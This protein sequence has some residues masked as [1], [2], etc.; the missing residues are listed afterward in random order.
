MPIKDKLPK[1]IGINEY[2]A[3]IN[4]NGIA[5]PN[6]YWVEFHMP[7][8]VQDLTFV[9]TG[10]AAELSNPNILQNDIASVDNGL[11]E[12]GSISVMCTASQMPGRSLASN[13]H[14]HQN[15]PINIPY[16]VN[17]ESVTFG[18]ILSENLR[19]RRYF[20]LWQET[21][22]NVNDGSM[23]FYNEY[24]SNIY[25]HHLDKWNNIM[26]SVEL[27]EAWPSALSNIDH[28]YATENDLLNMSVTFNYK[29]WRNLDTGLI[30]QR[31]SKENRFEYEKNF[32]KRL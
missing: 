6:R 24:T 26:Y 7:Q 28:S 13:Q 27:I 15:Y 16:S 30:K 17:Y 21:V 9:L 32:F 2:V 25:V 11:N 20:E 12:R 19:E 14:K 8:G 4:K 29:Y 23:N 31:K 5:A 1:N 22:V 3:G 10:D 18:F